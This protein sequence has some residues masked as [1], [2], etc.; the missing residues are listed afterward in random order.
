MENNNKEIQEYI[1]NFDAETSNRLNIIRDLAL[2]IMPNTNEKISFKMPSF[3]LNGVIFYYAGFKNHIGIFM[4]PEIIK[5][6]ADKLQSQNIKSSKGGIQFSD[7]QELPIDFIVE[8]LLVA[9]KNN[10]NK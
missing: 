9:Y 10:I 5:T 7:K 8:I 4:S 2:K 6:F 3:Y 1:A